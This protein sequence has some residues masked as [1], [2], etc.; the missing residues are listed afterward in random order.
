MVT[1]KNDKLTALID[2]LGAQLMSVKNSAGKEYIWQG[3]PK[4]W[5]DRAPVL[6]PIVSRLKNG[7]YSYK[8]KKY[9]MDMHGFA[10]DLEFQVEKQMQDQVTLLLTSNEETLKMYPF[11]FEFRVVY[12]LKGNALSVDFIVNNKTDGEMFFSVG[13]HEGYAIDSEISNYSIVLDE[14][15]TLGRY[16]V[17]KGYGLGEKEYPCFENSCELKLDE[18]YFTVDAIVFLNMKSRG[19]ALRDDRTGDKIH[20]SFPKAET[21]LVWR[22]PYAPFVCIEPW[23]GA[24]DIPW[25]LSDDFSRKFRIRKL[26]KG[27][28]ETIN[29][30]ITF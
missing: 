4:F 30:T 19:L 14:A 16:E 10:K 11:L 28:S 15:E 24:S 9:S 3:D 25:K 6:F 13:S 18:K 1:I 17:V 5:E 2:T 12:T 29:H 26:E 22:E 8:G 27:E 20:I 23:C 21:V 7:E